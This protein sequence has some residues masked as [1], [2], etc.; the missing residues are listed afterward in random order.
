[1]AKF[2]DI[3]DELLQHIR[4]GSTFK[5]ACQACDVSEGQF[6]EWKSK[7][8]DFADEVKAARKEAR[9]KLLPQLEEALMKRACGFETEE[10]RTEYFA[11]GGKKETIIRKYIP[12]ET[13]ALIFALINISDG[14]FKN[15]V[16]NEVMGDL[17]TNVTVEVENNSVKSEIEKLS[18]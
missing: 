4:D 2:N 3:K 5:E 6:Y 9:Q 16:Q 17:R 12:P 11:N 10:R 14:E 1:M 18:N 8:T 7:K 15:R 13:A